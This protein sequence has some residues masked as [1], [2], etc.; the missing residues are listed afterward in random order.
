MKNLVLVSLFAATLAACGGATAPAPP[1]P[2]PVPTA[3]KEA[4]TFL[5][6]LDTSYGTA[7]PATGA[8][9]NA[10]NDGCYFHDGVT[11]QAAIDSFNADPVQTVAFNKFR[12]GAT[13]SHMRVLAD[14]V[15]TN[16]AGDMTRRELDLEY[17]INYADGTVDP[18]HKQTIIT[19]NSAGSVMAKAA[20]CAT[21]ENNT[22]WRIYGNRSMLAAS[23]LAHNLRSERYNLATGVAL[24]SAV[25][26]S[27]YIALEVA[28]PGNFAKYVVI[29][30][31][32]LPTAGVKLLS[33]RVKRDDALLVG[34]VGHFVDLKNTDSFALCRDINFHVDADKADCKTYGSID[35]R[36][37]ALNLP[38]AAADTSFNALGFIAGSA[39]T[40][41]VYAD[42]NGWKSA[43]AHAIQTPIATL[44]RTLSALPY[45]AVALDEV[46]QV[47]ADLFPKFASTSTSPLSPMEIAGT[48]KSKLA[49]PF[50]DIAW[51]ALGTMPDASTFGWVNIASNLEGSTA[52]S[53]LANPWPKSK[54]SVLTYP[55]A[56][57]PPS[58]NYLPIPAA[59]TA[60]V[61]PTYGSFV[62]S[63]TNRVGNRIK[64]EMTFE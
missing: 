20:I 4:Q 53:T 35:N 5:T 46:L 6:A 15:T 22:K 17:Q 2:A 14:R 64:S 24:P 16:A 57:I 61:T 39:Y 40:I 60:T 10:L 8:A 23:V 25:D 7:V 31:A 18:A 38:A 1:A 28:D 47:S 3:L 13:R 9:D 34:K 41:A 29:K 62:M 50:M 54:L 30:G 43:N 36:H 37:G 58:P 44:T 52:A 33:P 32:G 45:S 27:K 48:I 49:N 26:Y 59:S 19:G 51:T 63:L 42:D 11:K 55:A 12:V 56:G 21:P